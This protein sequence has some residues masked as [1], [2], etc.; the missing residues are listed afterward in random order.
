MRSVVRRARNG[1]R[2][3]SFFE[4]ANWSPHGKDG[5]EAIV[6]VVKKQRAK[7]GKNANVEETRS[8]VSG[9]SC[10]SSGVGR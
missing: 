7:C 4:I 6:V 10:T 8:M 1:D 3:S 2:K 5:E 9:V